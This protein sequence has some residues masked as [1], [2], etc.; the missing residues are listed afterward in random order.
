M[1]KKR[2]LVLT[3]LY[4]PNV[5]GG[6]EMSAAEQ[7]N[8]LSLLGYEVGVVT[9]AASDDQV[10]NGELVDGIRIWRIK[11]PR[12][13]PTYRFA[14]APQFL[15]PIWHLQDHFDPRNR[16]AVREILRD[17]KPD[18]ANVHLIQ[19]LGYNILSELAQADVPVIYFVHDLGLACIKMSMFK[20]GDECRRQCVT[21]KVSAVWKRHLVS[22]V[23]RIGFCSPSRANL[24]TLAQFFPAKRYPT[25][26][27]L[28][29][30]RYPA[31]SVERVEAEH[32]RILYVGRLHSTKGVDFLLEVLSSLAQRFRFT[33]TVIGDG[34]E[35]V[36]L[37]KL[38]GETDWCR[39]TGFIDQAEI[40]NH[41]VNSDVMC[42]P[43]VWAENSPGVVIHALS[44]GLPLIG[45]N[46]GGIP[47]L[48]KHGVTGSLVQAGDRESWRVELE[49]LLL[50]PRKLKVWREN[51]TRGAAE[52]EVSRIRDRI[53]EFMKAV[54]A[55]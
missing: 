23:R 8:W 20:N 35:A 31:A 17:F 38:Y 51:A 6:A 52:F 28:N 42:I 54:E 1:K 2:V 15:K 11:P 30:N 26:A 7:S 5:L 40:S 16:T 34:P 48:I 37:R 4:P 44:L 45:T 55:S 27:I 9:T 3:S 13:Y 14:S 46:K 41:M 21:C 18:I 32:V 22:Q 12:P 43:S 25:A 10:L 39:F 36:K 53:T 19:G 50:D 33:M 49:Q 29:A 24:E 47:E